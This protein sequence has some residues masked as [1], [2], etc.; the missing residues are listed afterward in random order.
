[1]LNKVEWAPLNVPL[2]R[3]IQTLAAALEMF[4]VIL[5]HVASLIIFALLLVS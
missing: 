3:R 5:G 1:M 4:L 2:N